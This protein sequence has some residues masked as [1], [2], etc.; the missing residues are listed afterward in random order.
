MGI[1]GNLE[2]NAMHTSRFCIVFCSLSHLGREGGGG[3]EKEKEGV[4]GEVKQEEAVEYIGG[5]R[6]RKKRREREGR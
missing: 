1:F 3:E 5:G 4:G 6:R 2:P